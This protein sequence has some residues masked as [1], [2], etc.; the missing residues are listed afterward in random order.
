MISEWVKRAIQHAGMS[1]A[2][3]GRELTS[4][5][6]RSID[7]AAVNKMILKRREVS[8]DELLAIAEITGYHAPIDEDR[9][10]IVAAPL[11]DWV[12][13]G[14][15]SLR[16]GHTMQEE[17]P[18]VETIG[19]ADGRWIALRVE[20]DSMDRISPPESIIFVDIGDRKLIPNGLYVICTEEGEAT[21]KRYRANP[22]RFEPVTFNQA[23]EPI[24]PD[25][26]VRVIGRVRRTT[27]DM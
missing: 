8:A 6:G 7:R 15:P 24:F 5:L 26:R 4:R 27:L 9:S 19:L 10:T 22:E 23:H 20:G 16:E 21:Y 25:G 2:A 12:S 14:Q 11:I 1:Q 13:A 17:F 3:L 18:R